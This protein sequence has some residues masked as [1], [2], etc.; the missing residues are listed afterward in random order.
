MGRFWER[1]SG[2]CLFLFLSAWTGIS[3]SG[4]ELPGNPPVDSLWMERERPRLMALYEHLHAHP[5]LSLQETET[6]ERVACELEACGIEV[7]RGVAG[8]GLVGVL[9]NGPGPRILIRTDLDALPVE[10]E[11]G[12]PYASRVKARTESGET[13]G[14]MHACGHDVHMACFVGAARWLSSHREEWSGTILLIGQPA[15]ERV[16]GARAMLDGGLY[17]RYGKPDA[18]LAIHVQHD[19]EA[20]YVGY[21]SGPALAGS[22]AV[23]LIVK[24]KGGHGAMPH[25]AV[26]PV[27]LAALLIL[28]FQTIISREIAPTEPAV[29][30][31]G[32][33]Q[34]GTKHNIIPS[35]VKL[36]LTLR[37]YREEIRDRLIEGIKRRADGLAQAHLAPAPILSVKETTPPTINTPALV[38]QV[39]PV[40][41]RAFG[42]SCV[43]EVEP[44]MGAEDFGLFARDGVPIFM[45]RIGTGDPEQVQ[46]ARAGGEPVPSVHSA[47]YAPI[48]PPALQA[49]INAYVAVVRHLAPRRSE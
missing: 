18:A 15:E 30:T 24:G 29:I 35:E 7:T 33:I 17:A 12:L 32:S 28:D 10:E 19:L 38:E 26:D 46:A 25:S 27:V 11:T 41:E 1:R 45:M 47:R 16:V 6:S 44:T 37:A 14:V 49:G 40:L 39:R 42:P 3:A 4:D 21:R 23:D 22:A 48:V 20:G 8:T 36:Q 9:R 5:E 31:V 2:L 34:G 13:V 43:V